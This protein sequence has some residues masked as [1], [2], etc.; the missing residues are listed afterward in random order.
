MTLLFPLDREAFENEIS[1]VYEFRIWNVITDFYIADMGH[2]QESWSNYYM[3]RSQWLIV[4]FL[5]TY[6]EQ[7]VLQLNKLL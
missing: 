1:R 5:R 2:S 6:F 7:L 3:F 4:V